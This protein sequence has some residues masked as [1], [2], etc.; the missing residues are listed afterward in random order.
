[1]KPNIFYKENKNIY[2]LLLKNILYIEIKLKLYFTVYNQVY[3]SN[4]YN[5]NLITP[6]IEGQSSIFSEF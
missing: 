2:V 1:M 4:K 5:I 6:I 3:Y